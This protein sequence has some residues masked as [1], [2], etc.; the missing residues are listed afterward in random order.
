[1]VVFQNTQ[2]NVRIIKDFPR[3]KDIVSAKTIRPVLWPL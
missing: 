2:I 1:M 3:V